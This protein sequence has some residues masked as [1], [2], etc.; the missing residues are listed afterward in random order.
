[1][2]LAQNAF[3]PGSAYYIIPCTELPLNPKLLGL[4]LKAWRSLAAEAAAVT[5]WFLGMLSLHLRR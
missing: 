4:Q 5:D 3:A 2:L 1:M